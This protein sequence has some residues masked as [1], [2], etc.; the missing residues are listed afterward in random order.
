[1]VM[2]EIEGWELLSLIG[3]GACGRVFV[4]RPKGLTEGQA[5]EEVALRVFDSL[6]V[7]L[8]LLESMAG[9]L[10]AG[11]WP[12]GVVRLDWHKDGAGRRYVSMPLLADRVVD[13]ADGE[14]WQARTLEHAL[15]QGG[16]LERER[17]WNLIEQLAHVLAGMHQHRVPHGNLKPGSVFFSEEGELLLSD[18]AMGYMPGVSIEP[19]TDALLYAA[20]EQLQDRRGYLA[21][22]GYAWDVHAFGVMA[23]RML[24]GD[25]PDYISQSSQ[26]IAAEG[27]RGLTPAQ[28]EA[29]RL[30]GLHRLRSVEDWVAEDESERMWREII[31]RCMHPDPEVRFSDLSELVHAWHEMD[32]EARAKQEQVVLLKKSRSSRRMM[33]AAMGVAMVSVFVA[34]W[35]GWKLTGEQNT[36]QEEARLHGSELEQLTSD[37]EK[38]LESGTLQVRAAAL[39]EREAV[40]ARQAAERQEQRHREQLMALGVAND[41]LL[42]WMM[43]ERSRELPELDRAGRANEVISAELEGFLKASMEDGHY[44]PVRARAMM[45]LAELKIEKKQPVQADAWLDR[46]VAAWR[47]AGVEEPGHGY[48]VAR[49]RLAS[50]IQAIDQ[51]QYEE[52]RQWLPKVRQV[53]EA[54]QS[55][56][57]VESRRLAAVMHVIEARMLKQS[58]PEEALKHYQLAVEGMKGIHR[59]L[60][61][62]IRVRSEL[63]EYALETAEL[64]DALHQIDDAMRLRNEAAKGLEALLKENPGLEVAK[65]QLAAIHL[66]AVQA[67]IQQREDKQALGLLSKA[68]SLL[69]KLPDDDFSPSGAVAESATALGLRAV[70]LR[71]SGKYEAAKEKLNQAITLIGK[72]V[73]AQSEESGSDHEPLYRQAVFNWQLAGVLGD[74]GNRRAELEQGE[75]AADL[76]ETLLKKG[77]AEHELGVRRAL[78]YLYGDLGYTATVSGDREAAAGFYQSAVVIW[79]SLLDTFGEQEEY[80]DGLKWSQSKQRDAAGR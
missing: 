1:M 37:W 58:E 29:A 53:V 35:L 23:F 56:G 6:S 40:A 62:N 46:A 51:Q 16:G 65:V 77:A 67:A 9:R 43:R 39:A 61:E 11:H 48:R 41:H 27:P 66:L 52:A 25:F 3:E 49:A 30:S 33:I 80:R 68:E 79:Q 17:A 28:A 75:K 12:Q 24:S 76:M 18:Y 31:V 59:T 72:V 2:P 74:S 7:N 42:A 47:A 5:G 15:Q 63:A 45:Q 78:A 26:R 73:E 20:P 69:A 4:A 50:L 70:L 8:P 64:A 36:R 71:D 34:G 21:G 13:A 57:T 44:Q 22:K 14:S 19:L 32:L 10:D 38:Q 54:S 55:N 60:K